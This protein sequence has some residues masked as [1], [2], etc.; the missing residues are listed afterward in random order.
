[1][2]AASVTVD[3]HMLATC[4]KEHI[5]DY[6]YGNL[7]RILSREV[8]KHVTIKEHHSMSSNQKTYTA[9]VNV[10][11]TSAVGASHI[12]TTSGYNGTGTFTNNPISGRITKESEFRVLE[13]TKN[14]KPTR[15]ELQYY[16]GEDW[17]KVPRIKIEEE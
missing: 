11:S 2:I 12:T 1:M 6:V 15:V 14:G 8:M 4:T 7:E 9:T 16:D 13:F 3:D 10:G 5:E 17:Q